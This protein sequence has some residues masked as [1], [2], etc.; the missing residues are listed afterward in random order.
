V[1]PVRFQSVPA[2]TMRSQ[3]TQ[4]F[5]REAPY[6]PSLSLDD[7][8]QPKWSECVEGTAGILL[9]TVLF[10]EHTDRAKVQLKTDVD[11]LRA[12]ISACAVRKDLKASQF[13]LIFVYDALREDSSLYAQCED[14][15][16]EGGHGFFREKLE[17]VVSNPD[18]L[19]A[20]KAAWI[21]TSIMS[22]CSYHYTKQNA[23]GLLDLIFAKESKCSPLGKL[24]S[25]CNLLKCVDF[26]STAWNYADAQQTILSVVET[27]TPQQLYK[28][29]FA[30]WML[31]YDKTI[32]ATLQKRD[33]VP[34]IKKI[35]ATSRV[36]KVIRLGL[37]VIR[38]F[39]PDTA[40][41]QDIVEVNL[42]DVLQQL[43]FEKWR[44][45]EMYDDIREV[46]Q[47]VSVQQSTLSS[48]DKYEKEVNS[49]NLDWGYLHSNKFWGENINKFE[50]KE[51][52][53]VKALCTLLD[54]DNVTTQA[55]A[56]HDIGEFAVLHPLGKKKVEQFGVKAKV[57]KLMESDDR[58]VRREALLCCQKIMLNKWQDASK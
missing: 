26:R 7:L 10:K 8:P 6:N 12:C 30:L 38:N 46:M 32:A 37:V 31:S 43:E 56:C 25:S 11:L 57:M 9:Q 41:A 58:E 54:I 17:P 13:A 47:L 18:P 4:S 21:M 48:F 24:E 19:S 45:H 20:D 51:F 42:L 28:Y 22:N 5:N 15:L 53:V 14:I 36:E 1:R 2:M 34:V 44:D 40:L 52:G 3:T 39:L 23:T 50:Q 55:V 49:G 27:D 16:R 33:V 35:V 29:L